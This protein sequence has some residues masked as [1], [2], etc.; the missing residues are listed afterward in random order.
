MTGT[1]AL[2]AARRLV[3]AQQRRHALGQD[4]GDDAPA[5]GQ[6]EFTAPGLGQAAGNQQQ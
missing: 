6:H 1:P 5:A 2:A 4:E 3:A